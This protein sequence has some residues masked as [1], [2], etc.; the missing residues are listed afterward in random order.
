MSCVV[1]HHLNCIKDSER[2][3]WG[4][5][6]CFLAEWFQGTVET[7]WLIRSWATR[8]PAISSGYTQKLHRESVILRL[9]SNPW[10]T[11]GVIQN[12]DV[13]LEMKY[14]CYFSYCYDKIFQQQSKKRKVYFS[15]QLQGI[16]GKS[17][18]HRLEVVVPTTSVVREVGGREERRE[19]KR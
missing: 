16:L 3:E 15:L 9:G 1:F 19:E 13:W 6:S 12:S 2:R 11:N 10:N 7:R 14:V 17:W 18:K 5:E 4:C 8:D